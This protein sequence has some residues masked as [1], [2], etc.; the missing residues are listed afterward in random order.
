MRKIEEIVEY[1]M[2]SV[3]FFITPHGFGHAARS[4]A[5]VSALKELRPKLKI[6]VFT[7]VPKTFFQDSIGSDF[8]YYSV[9]TDIGF[10]QKSSLEI[11]IF[12]TLEALKEF[13][14][15][16]VE[17]YAQVINI[18]KKWNTRLIVSD[19]SALGI[20]LGMAC[21]IRTVLVENFTWD[22][23]YAF[24]EKEFPEFHKYTNI[25]NYIYSKADYRIRT[26]PYCGKEKADLIVPPVS[27]RVRA[28]RESVRESLGIVAGE[29]MVLLTMGGVDEPM[30]FLDSRFSEGLE[31]LGII[32]VCP[33]Q[34]PYSQRKGNIVFLPKFSQ[35]FHPDLVNAS[36][37]V[38]AKLGYATLAEVL[39]S[40]V[41]Y[42]F[43]MRDGYPETDHL[44]DYVLS[45]G[46]TLEI[47]KE[48][49][50]NGL[51]LEKIEALLSMGRRECT[52]ENGASAIARF[53]EGL[54]L[55]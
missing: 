17:K 26:I 19:I 51:L 46:S 50:K 2:D 7:T 33:Q 12:W 20:V 24:Y 1:P 38:V 6:L 55:S 21:N 44:K 34:V 52:W 49:F 36:D 43:V 9:L 13:Y 23:I 5:I 41:P 32:L 10:V 4:C 54:L 25:L 39:N 31:R 18:L 15:I 42:A 14:P 16:E 48:Q 37:G 11:D 29:R 8:Y 27:R 45:F 3:A 35:Y 28:N 30:E 40:G 47:T 22:W 53:L